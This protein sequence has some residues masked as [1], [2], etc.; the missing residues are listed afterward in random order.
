MF[1]SSVIALVLIPVLVY[2]LSR[3]SSN[4]NE[5]LPDYMVPR[6]VDIRSCA[7]HW[8]VPAGMTRFNS[9]LLTEVKCH[10][11]FVERNV[12]E[13]WFKWS[14]ADARKRARKRLVLTSPDGVLPMRKQA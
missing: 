10:P 3:K 8:G 14:A 4:G 7:T 12:P 2:S 13:T 11:D 9:A 5:I 6:G 1:D